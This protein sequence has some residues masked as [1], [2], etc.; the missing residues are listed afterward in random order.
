[1]FTQFPSNSSELNQW[2]D[3]VAKAAI[4]VFQLTN[5]E[6]SSEPRSGKKIEQRAPPQPQK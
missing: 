4:D 5:E 3:M 6:E 2:L 1:M